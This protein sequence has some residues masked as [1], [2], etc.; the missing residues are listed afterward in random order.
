MFHFYT[1]NHCSGFLMVS[2]IIELEH[3]LFWQQ[4][5]K[6]KLTKES[7]SFLIPVGISYSKL[8]L[9]AP[10]IPE[11]C[12]KIKIWAKFFPLSGIGTGRVNNKG[13]RA[14]SM[15]V[16]SIFYCWHLP[17]YLVLICLLNVT[18][19]STRKRYEMLKVNNNNTRM[20]F[21]L[22]ILNIFRTFF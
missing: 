11:S 14:K 16:C 6:K 8:T 18:N 22:L 17:I 1:L 20:V 10:Y 15:D 4:W 5:Y 9:F 21:L 19:G 12:I 13:N 2:G 3:W 7:A